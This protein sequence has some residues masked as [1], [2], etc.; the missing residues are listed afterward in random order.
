M[1][2]YIGVDG[3]GTKTQTVLFQEDGHILFQKKGKGTNP[4]DIGVEEA[5]KR[6]LDLMLEAAFNCP[7]KLSSVY[8]GVAGSAVF[9]LPWLPQETALVRRAA[10]AANARIFFIWFVSYYWLLTEVRGVSSPR[11]RPA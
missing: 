6:L 3:G 1:K 4:L 9:F 11:G 5:R 7:G 8:A 10:M 2:Y